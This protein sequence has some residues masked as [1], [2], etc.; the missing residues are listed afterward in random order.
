MLQDVFI[1]DSILRRLAPVNLLEEDS[2]RQ[3][4]S[5]TRSYS[6]PPGALLESKLQQGWYVYVVSGTAFHVNNKGER[7]GSVQAKTPTAEHPVFTGGQNDGNI[8]AKTHVEFLRIDR[9]LV[10]VLMHRQVNTATEVQEFDFDEDDATIFSCIYDAFSAKSLKVPSLPE[11][12]IEV[13]KALDDPDMGFAEIA[14][15]VKQDPPYTAR[16]I[17]LSN[18]AAYK[19]SS[20]IDTLSLAISRIGVKSVRSLLM[21]V[22]VEEMIGNVHPMAVDLL[23]I[24]YK[25]AA[26]IAALCFVLAR[27]LDTV[28]EERAL[29]AGLLH[30]LGSVPLISHAFEALDSPDR[31]R[32]EGAA[33]RLVEP[34]TSWML[35]E[36]QLDDEL[37][38]IADSVS[39]WYRPCD[40][41][42]GL[43]ETVIAARLLLEARDSESPSVVLASTPIGQK[44]IEKGLNIQDPAAFFV[45]IAEDLEVARELV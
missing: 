12:M 11:V 16:L 30:Q 38:N 28:A 34:V 5:T 29:M 10:D 14:N 31:S 25:E 13:N 27:R 22:A 42:I 32:I 26:E 20:T 35:G 44:F 6:L 19:G 9:M 7:Y 15:I 41:D 4:V 8:E 24:Y 43:L 37:C 36:W 18:S 39:D 45:E 1:D 17:Q 33:K 2:Y 3:V 23:R 21:G 40:G